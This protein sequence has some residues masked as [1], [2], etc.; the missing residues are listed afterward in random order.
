MRPTDR[1]TDPAAT[2]LLLPSLP[3]ATE[4][5]AGL[6]LGTDPLTHV[7]VAVEGPCCGS[8]LRLD[9]EPVVLGRS[10]A[11]LELADPAVSSRHCRLALSAGD[12]VVEDLGSSNGTFVEGRAI[13][14]PTVL[15]VGRPLRIGST[16]FAHEL[17]AREEAERHEQLSQDLDRA[18]RY[19]ESLLPP[20]SDEPDLRLRWRFRPCSRLGGDAFGYHWIDDDHL[21]IYLLDVCGHGVGSALH[22]VSVVQLLR[23]GS[24]VGVDFRDPARVL[25]ALDDVF[26]MEQHA[27]MYFTAWYGVYQ[28]S[29]RR[30]R[31]ASAGHPPAL[32]LA[33]GEARPLHTQRPPVGW[34][35]GLS[36]EPGEAHLPGASRLYLFSDGAYELRTA[37]G[38]YWTLD[39]FLDLL[40]RTPDP[41]PEA[42]ISGLERAL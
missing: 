12:V 40:A 18:A 34:L 41:D 10:G 3:E 38:T 20:P 37:D 35:E 30:L 36:V 2:T 7:L 9:A 27:G 32:L 33:G 24:L 28:R 31:Y 15:A 8:R 39:A 14:Q 42:A 19:V 4:A 5:G 25:R 16:V 6:A 21:A 26:P 29:G 1:E 17:H 13:D 23:S 11:D 22:S